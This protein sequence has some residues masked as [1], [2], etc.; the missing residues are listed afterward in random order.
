MSIFDDLYLKALGG[1]GKAIDTL[2]R[3]LGNP[4]PETGFS[5]RLEAR[6]SGA[7]PQYERV[8]RVQADP[9]FNNYA[10]TSLVPSRNNIADQPSFTG[11]GSPSSNRYQEL[12]AIADK[13]GL[14]PSQ[15]TEWENLNPPSGGGS[16]NDGGN[17]DGGLGAQIALARE[18]YENRLGDLRRAFDQAQGIYDEGVGLINKRR[19][20]FRDIYDTGN[21]DILSSFEGE[22]GNLQRSSV[23]NKNRLRNILRATG[24]GGSALVRGTQSQDKAN[25]R[26]LG[27]L[28]E[29]KTFNERENLKGYN[30]NLDFANQ[31]ESALGRFLQQAQGNYQSGVE[32]AGLV[33]A[34]DI[35][36]INNAFDQLRS[37]IYNQQ[38]ALAAARGDIGA[39]TANPFA[40]NIS[41]MTNS[42][43]LSLPQFADGGVNP[44]DQAVNLAPENLSVLDL[45]KRRAGG[46]LYA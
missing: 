9:R 8:A 33:N 22:R 34:G 14:N 38:A 23:G 29:E 11:A 27:N 13:G 31:Q 28:S 6:G 41:D 21:A 30:K 36:A 7:V 10:G 25:L 32:K 15:R 19:G 39:Y 24:M 1:A 12:K 43:N 45:L 46:S 17:N 2:G 40:P 44:N 3:A 35:A 37:N 20:E 18:A 4:L 26:N 5:E 42:L 16:N